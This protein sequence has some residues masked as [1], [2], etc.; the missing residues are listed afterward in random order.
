MTHAL[1]EPKSR[2]NF[3]VS[4]LAMEKNEKYWKKCSVVFICQVIQP[5]AI[6]TGQPPGG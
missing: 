5:V 3:S 6:H 2:K 4:G 1:E